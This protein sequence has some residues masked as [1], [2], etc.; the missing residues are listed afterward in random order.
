MNVP[1]VCRAPQ[2]KI[3]LKVND[4]EEMDAVAAYAESL[5]LVTHVV[6]G[7]EHGNFAV[8]VFRLPRRCRIVRAG[9]GRAIDG[10]CG[11]VVGVH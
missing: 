3:A 11:I 4:E 5:G 1:P 8:V 7:W 6:V 9:V 10:D 2:V